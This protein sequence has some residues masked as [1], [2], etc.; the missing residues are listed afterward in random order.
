MNTV[1]HKVSE[2]NLNYKHSPDGAISSK[3]LYWDVVP[4]L[5]FCS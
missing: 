1:I 3:N 5:S 4:V 2:H